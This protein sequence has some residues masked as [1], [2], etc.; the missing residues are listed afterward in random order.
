MPE[1]FCVIR[2]AGFDGICHHFHTC[3]L[4]EIIGGHARDRGALPL[5]INE[6]EAAQRFVADVDRRD[7]RRGRFGQAAETGRLTLVLSPSGA[8]VSSVM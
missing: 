8:M 2:E 4:L 1:R 5:R 7:V 3:K 6:T